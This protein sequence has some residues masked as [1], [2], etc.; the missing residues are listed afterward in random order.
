MG[1]YVVLEEYRGRGIG[2]KLWKT[3]IEHL[4]D[5]NIGVH[6]DPSN[7]KKYREKEGFCHVEDY[8]ILYYDCFGGFASTDIILHS[9]IEVATYFEGYLIGYSKKLCIDT[10]SFEE[11]KTHIELSKTKGGSKTTFAEREPMVNVKNFEQFSFNEEQY[12]VGKISGAEH[13]D[14]SLPSSLTIS[15]SPMHTE[16]D[17][18][19]NVEHQL[20]SNIYIRKGF[21]EFEDTSLNLMSL[22]TKNNSKSEEILSAVFAFDK[23]LHK[24]DRSLILRQTFSWSS[25]RSK[26]ALLQGKVIGYACLRHVVTEHWIISPFYADTEDIAEMLLYELLQE[27]D[28]S[29][30]P[31]GIQIRFP[32]K[33][34]GCKRLVEKFGFRKNATRILT[35]FTK[36][37]MSIDTSKV[38]SFHSTVFCSE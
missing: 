29:Q 25:C 34:I 35:G 23:L 7:F 16:H 1:L 6:G 14:E 32:D 10:C 20:H 31:K 28:F 33:N 36:Q 30:A 21:N 2:L 5:R 37:C 4:G 19:S 13:A 3:A 26:V 8:A 27:F 15:N 9:D 22:N 18:I 11:H 17:G 12:N 24:R 38:Y